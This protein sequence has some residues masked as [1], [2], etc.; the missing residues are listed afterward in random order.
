M[1]AYARDVVAAMGWVWEAYG[2][3]VR[4]VHGF[5]IIGGGLIEDGTVGALGRLSCG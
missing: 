1:A 2:G 4:V 5:P 3:N